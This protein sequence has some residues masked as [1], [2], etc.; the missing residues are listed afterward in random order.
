MRHRRMQERM[1]AV[2]VLML[3]FM[4]YLA[5]RLQHVQAGQADFLKQRAQHQHV[6]LIPLVGLR[7]AILDRN[8]RVLSTS[9]ALRSIAANPREIANRSTAALILSRALEVPEQRLRGAL[10]SPHTFVWL[11]RK[12]PDHI[13][14]RVERLRIDGV[15]TLAEE[16]GRRFHPKGRLAS[17]VLGYTGVDD[18]GLDGIEGVFEAVLKGR[19]GHLEAE[20]DRDGN[21]LAHGYTRREP[22]R[23]G[24]SVTLTIDD[25]IQYQVERILAEAVSRHRARGAVCI[26]MDVASG[27]VLAMASAPD[28]DPAEVARTPA[29][30]LRNRAVSD[31]YEPGST[32]KIFLAAAGLDSGRISASERFFCGS[33]MVVDGWTIHNANDGLGSPT[34]SEDIEGILT[35]SFNVGTAAAAM[36]L[37]TKEWRAYLA[38]FGFG[39]ATGIALPGEAEGL[40]PGEWRDITLATTSFGQGIAV[41]PLQLV[42]GMQAVANNGLRMRPRIVREI[43]ASDGT[44]VRTIPATPLGRVI[45]PDTSR[46]L[47]A[48][49]RNV[50]TRG[51]GRA[52]DSPEYPAAG[53]TGTAQVA[54]DGG[55]A[56]GRYVASFLGFAP[57]HEP[58]VAI[59]VKVDEPA[60][61]YWGGMVA[62]PIF[63]QVSE[64]TLKRL[65]VRPQLQDRLDDEPL[66]ASRIH[67]LMRI[68]DHGRGP[69]PSPAGRPTR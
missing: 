21:I 16:A 13:A 15:F 5:L 50:V 53:K 7:G 51:T 66:T 58:R 42:S 6:G 25:A 17:H 26:V 33:S 59:L 49:L 61:I 37:G 22:A 1:L 9:L 39:R 47:R 56:A 55:Y 38:R 31:A 64:A 69:D 48:M 52:A 10:A 24:H 4:T 29:H 44:L 62:A 54:V 35:W 19:P 60:G 63:R 18:D 41:T 34:G 68:R 20:M 2:F 23:Q 11:A 46:R 40:L 45:E 12:A 28:F 30:L 32:F 8:G 27:D 65:G 43:R 14:D 3:G 36:K 67:G 57:L